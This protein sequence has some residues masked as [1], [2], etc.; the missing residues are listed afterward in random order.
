MVEL[1][2]EL[3]G[4]GTEFTCEYPEHIPQEP[5]GKYRFCISRVRH[6]YSRPQETAA[7]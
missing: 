4:S 1:A 7:V 5:S 3:F 6:P 2:A